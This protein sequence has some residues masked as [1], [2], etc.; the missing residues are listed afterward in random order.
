MT[1]SKCAYCGSLFKNNEEL[2]KH[3]DKI[4]NASEPI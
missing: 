1:E 4:H 3:V 2:S